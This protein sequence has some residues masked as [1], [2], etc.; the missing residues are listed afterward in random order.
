MID[1]ALSVLAL[2]AG[3]LALELYA[4]GGAPL[5]DQDDKGFR[6]DAEAQKHAEGCPGEQPA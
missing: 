2:V 5:R 1:V 3:G 4:A 6:W